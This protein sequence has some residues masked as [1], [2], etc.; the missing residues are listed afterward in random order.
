MVKVYNAYA[1][2]EDENKKRDTNRNSFK[3]IIQCYKIG[4]GEENGLAEYFVFEG[5]GLETKECKFNELDVAFKHLP[6]TYNEIH[7]QVIVNK[8]RFNNDELLL[9]FDRGNLCFGGTVSNNVLTV[10]TD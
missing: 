9:L 6:P 1:F 5:D 3:K 10:F 8:P 2:E 4:Y 7:A